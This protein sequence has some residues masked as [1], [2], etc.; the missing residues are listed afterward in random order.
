MSSFTVYGFPGSAYVRAV[1]L[2]LEEKEAAYELVEMGPWDHRTPE[3]LARHPFGKMPVL[4][5]G[6]FR[7]YETQAILRYIDRIIPDPPLTPGKPRREARMNQIAGITDWYVT[8]DVSAGIS[9][10]R[11][12]ATRFGLPT[13]EQAISDA[14]PRAE[15]CVGEIARIIGEGPFVAGEAISLGDLILAPQLVFLQW[16]PEGRMLLAKHRN[17]A[18]W[19]DRM[20]A[21]DSMRKTHWNWSPTT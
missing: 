13:D 4:D 20:N 17:L 3:H 2:C 11:V 9:F 6:D 7:L 1:L 12:F 8:K 15:L 18:G 5:H 10:G 21:R 16:S 19:I 14:L